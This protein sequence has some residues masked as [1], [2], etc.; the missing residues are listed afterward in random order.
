MSAT[1]ACVD[2][3]DWDIWISNDDSV[4]GDFGSLLLRRKR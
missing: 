2:W 4:A 3:F 1:R